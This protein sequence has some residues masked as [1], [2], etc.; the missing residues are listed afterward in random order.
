MSAARKKLQQEVR[1]HEGR[2]ERSKEE[3]KRNV[4]QEDHNSV[5]KYSPVQYRAVQYSTVLAVE[6][7]AVWRWLMPRLT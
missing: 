3:A 4:T 5:M 1:R 2:D 6:Q 7:K